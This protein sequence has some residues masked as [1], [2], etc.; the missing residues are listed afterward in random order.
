MKVRFLGI[1][2]AWPPSSAETVDHPRQRSPHLLPSIYS[3]SVVRLSSMPTYDSA[4]MDRARRQHFRII[5][6][7]L[8]GGL[9]N[10]NL[11]LDGELDQLR[12][13]VEV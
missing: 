13:R 8:P 6:L 12:S 5:Q 7:W 3:N 4:G 1:A 10:K 11:R 9:R 2:A